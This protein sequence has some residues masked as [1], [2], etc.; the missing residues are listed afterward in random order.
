M[1]E[2]DD[3]PELRLLDEL[4]EDPELRLLLDRLDEEEELLLDA[5]EELDDD[6]VSSIEIIRSVSPCGKFDAPGNAVWVVA[7]LSTRW[8]LVCP[9]LTSVRTAWQSRPSSSSTA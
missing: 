7:K 6:D 2:L 8:V 1:D 9:P 5:L 4:D 3:E